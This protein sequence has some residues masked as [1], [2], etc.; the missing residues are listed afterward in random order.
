[1]NFYGNYVCRDCQHCLCEDVITGNPLIPRLLEP[2]CEVKNERLL[3]FKR[4][5]C[6]CRDFILREEK[7]Y[8]QC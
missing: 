4:P 1:M 5:V 3:S 6:C 2:F 7:T 8:G